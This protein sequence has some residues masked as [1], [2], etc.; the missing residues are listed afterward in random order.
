MA[1]REALE[2]AIADGVLSKDQAEKLGHYLQ[3][4][5]DPYG[6]EDPENLK[7][8]SSFNDVFLTLGL[9]ILLAGI[10]IAAI[11]A[12][13][14][15]PDYGLVPVLIGGTV[16]ASA[17]MLAEYFGRRR[18]LALPTMALATAFCFFGGIAI[19][20]L[21]TKLGL[22]DLKQEFFRAA[23]Q[24]DSAER[25]IFNVFKAQAF[26]SAYWAQLGAALCAVV[27]YF[28]FRLP[29]SLFLLAVVAA[30][31]FYTFLADAAGLAML[32]GGAILT[33]GIVT[34]AA[35]MTFD[36]A[37]PTRS[38]RQ[39]DN[40]FWLH[41]AAAPQIMLGLRYLIIGPVLESSTS[42]AFLMLIA[43]FLVGFLSLALNRRALIFSGLVTFTLV[44]FSLARQ[45]GL[46]GFDLAMWPLLIVGA[47]VVLLGAGWGSAR[48]MVLG[49]VPES[50]VLARLFPTEDMLKGDK[51]RT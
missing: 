1:D 36:A 22:G 9:I 14:G 34:L 50:G 7:F 20:A 13:M 37:D 40:A 2:K 46:S 11:I 43:L 30:M 38:T 8:L 51:K 48:R 24:G 33:A 31:T 3:R 35:A 6:G 32:G 44:V 41:L 19:G 42:S 47:S 15:A 4:G 39:S 25:E 12:F 28:R 21:I 29:F 16:A 10:F 45:S 49:F 26:S 27:F 5:G 23:A 18:R 17:W